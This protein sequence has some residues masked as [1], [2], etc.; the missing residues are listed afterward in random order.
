MKKYEIIK[1][2]I[3]TTTNQNLVKNITRLDKSIQGDDLVND[4]YIHHFE[5]NIFPNRNTI[6]NFLIDK[7]RKMATSKRK[8]N[9]VELTEIEQTFSNLESEEDIVLNEIIYN[10]ILKN[11]PV[12]DSNLLK[13]K[14]CYGA[15]N[16]EIAGVLNISV[17]GVKK[18]LSRIIKK[19]KK[20]MIT[21][22]QIL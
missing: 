2:L 21:F 22:Y 8:S 9:F 7:L 4:I 13:L 19:I 11:L 3:N 14:Y 18:R 5:K 15:T 1:K 6:K 12:E 16:K 10:N 20:T 17:I